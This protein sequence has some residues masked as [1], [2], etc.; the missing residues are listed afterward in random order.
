M[1][2]VEDL[3]RSAGERIDS[4]RAPIADAL[5]TT[6]GSVRKTASSIGNET[7]QSAAE[8]VSGAL[9]TT[10]GYLRTHNMEDMVADV[11]CA[12]R[13]NPVPSMI[14]AAAVGFLLGRALMKR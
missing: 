2:N 12:A 10:A 3:R 8:R 7:L 11:Q 14:A 5:E 6:A 9:G 4:T 1:T 13:E